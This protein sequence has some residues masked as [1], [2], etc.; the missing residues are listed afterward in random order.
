MEERKLG[1]KSTVLEIHA[2]VDCGRLGWTGLLY[3]ALRVVYW[4]MKLF[5]CE[6][7]G[8]SVDTESGIAGFLKRNGG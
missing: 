6:T 8:H 3:R 5:R 7:S 2:L 1:R 4:R